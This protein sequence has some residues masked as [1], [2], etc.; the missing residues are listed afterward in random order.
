[1][2]S[3][4]RCFLPVILGISFLAG[5]ELP[6]GK[7]GG[8]LDVS[9]GSN[10]LVVKSL[11][12]GAPGQVAGLQTGDM[13]IGAEGQSFSETPANDNDGYQ[14]ALVD[15]ATAMEFAASQDG[16]LDLEIVRSG[17]GGVSV[18][19]D[20]GTTALGPVW[21]GTSAKG[22]SIF[23]EACAEIHQQVQ[24]SGSDNFG[25][26]TGWYGLILLSHPDWNSTSGAKPYRNSINQLRTRC[27][28]FLNGRILEPLEPYYFDGT[29]VVSDPNFTSPGLE[30][31]DICS[32][33]IF[34][35]LYRSKTG[36]T[37][38]N[39]VVQRAATMIAHRIQSWDQY[40]D[41]GLPHVLGGGLGRMGHGGV[42]GDYSHYNG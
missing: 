35:S 7:L 20:I 17:V 5:E 15:L 16:L 38:A 41:P 22:N 29:D 11:T 31:W 39:A 28:N 24:G 3:L 26:N 27:E 42:S 40:D 14:G 37:S 13:I 34:L 8:T 10:V 23:E 2:L 4:N 30:N 21:P 18:I 36:D 9:P 32:S 1:M 12:G 6:M 33:A 19:A 25:Y